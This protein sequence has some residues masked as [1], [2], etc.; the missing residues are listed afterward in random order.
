MR[1]LF[2]PLVVGV[3]SHAMLQVCLE[4]VTHH[5][6]RGSFFDFIPHYFEGWYGFG[7]KFAWM[8]L[9]LWYLL[10]LFVFSLIL[11]PLLCWLRDGSGQ[12]IFSRCLAQ[13]MCLLYRWRGWW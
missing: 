3:F 8:G 6:F 13:S 11:Y 2:V 5:Q 9:H 12:A 7:G 4:R 10:I 1:R